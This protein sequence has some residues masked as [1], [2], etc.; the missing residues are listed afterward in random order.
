MFQYANGVREQ[1]LE[2]FETMEG[3]DLKVVLGQR[4]H[5]IHFTTTHR[6]DLRAVL[7]TTR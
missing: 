4:D 3:N 7:E 2:L 1:L 6:Q 5:T